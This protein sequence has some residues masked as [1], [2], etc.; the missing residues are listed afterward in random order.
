MKVQELLNILKDC[1]PEQLVV[2]ND[3]NE[4]ANVLEVCVRPIV[5]S[6]GGDVFHANKENFDPETDRRAN[7]VVIFIDYATETLGTDEP[8]TVA[9]SPQ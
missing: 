5:I 1:N 7:G 8:G 6:A 4:I 9:G 2:V 3:G